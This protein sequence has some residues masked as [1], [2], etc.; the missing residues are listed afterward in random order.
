MDADVDR[1]VRGWEK[2]SDHAPVWIAIEAKAQSRPNTAAASSFFTALATM[3]SAP[4]GNGRRSAK[5]RSH[6]SAI[7]VSHC[8]DVVRM[9][10]IAFGYSQAAV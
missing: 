3:L 9:T 2:A 1:Q 6:G 8:S 7:H 10:D 5:A 4:S